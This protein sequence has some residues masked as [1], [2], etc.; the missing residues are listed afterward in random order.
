MALKKINPDGT[1]PLHL[2]FDI[3]ALDPSEAPAT[4]TP[5]RGGLTLRE[6]MTLM[7]DCFV[8]GN[9]HAID[10]AEVNTHLRDYSD[11]TKTLRAAKCVIMS[12]L[13][14]YRGGRAPLSLSKPKAR[15]PSASARGGERIAE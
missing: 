14:Y 10:I 2:S 15:G 7:E 12:A 3:D 8:H 5:V 1:R 13:G 4:G 9:L 11:G 6:A